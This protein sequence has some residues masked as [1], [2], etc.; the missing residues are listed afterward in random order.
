VADHIFHYAARLV[1][2]TR[3][4]EEEAPDFIKSWISYGA[5]PRAS[6][7][8]IIAGKARAILHGRFHVAIEDIKAVA[9]P[10]LRHRITPNFAAQSEG[11]TSDDIVNKLIEAT[12]AD[13]PLYENK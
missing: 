3:P 12:P 4:S 10:I 7:N 11:L 6:L 8:L 9:P 13:E 2:S 1:R 5:G